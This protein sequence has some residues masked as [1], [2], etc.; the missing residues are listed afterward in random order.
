[1]GLTKHQ[2]NMKHKHA[3]LMAEYAK[4]AM[5]TETPWERWESKMNEAKNW[6]KMDS[7]PEWRTCAEYRRK[8]EPPKPR[9]WRMWLDD[10]ELFQSSGMGTRKHIRVREILESEQ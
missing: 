6:R 2:P 9:E 3:E 1:M 8:P 5:T 10:G 7:H 4:D